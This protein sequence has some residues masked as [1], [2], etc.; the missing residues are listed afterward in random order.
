[1]Q[2]GLCREQAESPGQA[3]PGPASEELGVPASVSHSEPPLPPWSLGS[4]PGAM[5]TAVQGLKEVT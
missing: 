5:L 4:M 2:V 1:M 3:H